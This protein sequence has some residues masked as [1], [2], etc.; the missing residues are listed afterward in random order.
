[1]PVAV[2]N[3]KMESAFFS[4]IRTLADSAETGLWE[5]GMAFRR[6]VRAGSMGEAARTQ[7]AFVHELQKRNRETGRK[8]TEIW[9]GAV[10][11]ESASP[12]SS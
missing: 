3:K 5:A 6:L 7:A 1:M 8:L 11:G 12:T 10:S 4:S 9:R 2:L